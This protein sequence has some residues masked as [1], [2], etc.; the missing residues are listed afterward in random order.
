M[1]PA[2]AGLYKP[3]PRAIADLCRNDDFRP[4]AFQRF[5]EQ[6]LGFTAA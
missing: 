1:S 4:A 6:G 2:E 5:P 3:G